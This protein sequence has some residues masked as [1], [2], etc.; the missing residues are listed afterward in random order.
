MKKIGFI[1]YFLDEWH[2]NNY[3]AW[4]SDPKRGG[5]Y[6]VAWAWA[7]T[8]RG[9]TTAQWCSKY[10]AEQAGS[11]QE[12]IEKSDCIVV[13][14]PD[15]AQRH[16]DLSRLALQSGKP[17]YVDKTFATSR[18]SAERMFDLAEKHGTPMYSTSAL[19]Y[20]DE[21]KWPAENRI[22]QKDVIYANTSG[23]GKF[24]TYSIHQIEMIVAA[25]GTGVKRGIAFS[26]GAAPVIAYE[27]NDGRCAFVNMTA[28]EGFS[29]ALQSTGGLYGRFDIVS[30]FWD[31]FIDALLAFFDTGK[32]S[33]A[34]EET[35]EA[36][37]MIEAGLE[38]L[39]KPGEWVRIAS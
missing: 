20:A 8:E 35:C 19:R 36:M 15:H 18:R 14:S 34:R 11:Q 21:L 16:E 7:E 39:Q 13:L 12:L 6:Q 5:R 3:P 37:A 4:I 30:N 22:A 1:D 26:A 10:G 38:A 33:V 24:D 27:Y 28:A 25:M 32:P 17:V 2:A 23:P 9:L 29:I 31:G